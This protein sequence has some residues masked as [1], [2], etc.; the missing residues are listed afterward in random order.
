MAKREV[1]GELTVM[2]PQVQRCDCG[3]IQVPDVS[4]LSV[5]SQYCMISLDD[6]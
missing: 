5:R 2:V 4:G 1:C 3:K 6:V